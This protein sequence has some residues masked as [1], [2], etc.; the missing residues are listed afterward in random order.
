MVHIK[1]LPDNQEVAELYENHSTYH[2]GDSGL[3]LFCP[4]T[5]TINP[6]ETVKINLQINCEALHDTIENTNV[7][8]YLYRCLLLRKSKFFYFISI[9]TI[10]I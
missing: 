7:S 5:I 2:E 3:D 9:L 8:Y 1:I 6:G 4:E 10:S